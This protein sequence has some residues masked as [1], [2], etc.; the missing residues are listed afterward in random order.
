VSDNMTR[1]AP[2][3]SKIGSVPWGRGDVLSVQLHVVEIATTPRLPRNTKCRRRWPSPS[4]HAD[5]A[6]QWR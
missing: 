3:V 6:A 2:I 5:V 4:R 1:R